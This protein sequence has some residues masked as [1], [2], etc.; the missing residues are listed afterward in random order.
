MSALWTL[1]TQSLLQRIGQTTD[2]PATYDATNGY[3]LDTSVC[4]AFRDIYQKICGSDW[5]IHTDV[6]TT[7]MNLANLIANR[8]FK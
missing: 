2:S 1:T 5:D 6:S 4:S 7:L 3:A 8:V